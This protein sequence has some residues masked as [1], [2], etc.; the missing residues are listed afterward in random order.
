[1]SALTAG[2]IGAPVLGQIQLAVNETMTQFG[3]E[4]KKDADLAVLD[5]AGASAILGSDPCRVAAAFGKAAFIEDENRIER[6]V[7]G[8]GRK[9]RRWRE[10][11]ADQGAHGV[12][13]STLIPDGVG[14]Q[15]LHAVGMLLANLFSDLPAVFARN[16]AENG[17][18]VA[19]DL[20]VNFGAGKMRTQPAMQLS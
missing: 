7:V 6:L 9:Q 13:D 15:A 14:E 17:V 2:L 1:M 19:Q 16:V 4:G 10:G 12:A 3:D 11:V 20:R 5:A 8:G 18:Q